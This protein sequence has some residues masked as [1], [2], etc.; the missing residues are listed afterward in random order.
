MERADLLRLVLETLGD[1]TT[2]M[3]GGAPDTL[4]EKTSLFGPNGV[5]DSIGLVSFLTDLEDQVNDE[6]EAEIA[7]A[8]E[9]ALSAE[10]SPFRSVASLVDHVAARLAEG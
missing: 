9:R 2:M 7:I 4:D 3:P 5:F 1:Y 10:K 6:A 8:D